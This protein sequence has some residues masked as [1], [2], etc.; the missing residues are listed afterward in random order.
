MEAE[1]GYLELRL[2]ILVLLM[3]KGR[4]S[5]ILVS[6]GPHTA[7]GTSAVLGELLWLGFQGHI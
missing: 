5:F 6:S 7:C 1:V 2:E 4:V 3:V